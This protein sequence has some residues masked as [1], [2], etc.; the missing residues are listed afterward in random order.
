[1]KRKGITDLISLS[2]FAFVILLI[3]LAIGMVFFA[4][5]HLKG[6]S[7][8]S[9]IFY[10]HVGSAINM[11]IIFILAGLF[12][13]VFLLSSRTR[14]GLLA[15]ALNCACAEVGLILAG[16][17]L[18]T[19]PLWAKKEWGTF[20]TWEPRLTLSLLIFFLFLSSLTLRVFAQRD[21]LG[22][23]MSAGLSLLGIPTA[24]FIHFAVEKWG[25]AHPQ[26]IYKGGL[27]SDTTRQILILCV[28]AIAIFCAYLI[29]LRTKIEILK[30][31]IDKIFL[32]IESEENL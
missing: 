6:M 20:W 9:K 3:P 15:D 8:A 4:S 2:L 19:G 1:M 28:I 11:L 13:L 25:G 24:W 30:S 29:L 14:I 22:K 10:F 7:I 27:E 21:R 23:A 12:G 32:Q 16:I 5:P 31:H 26:V 17:V 18:V